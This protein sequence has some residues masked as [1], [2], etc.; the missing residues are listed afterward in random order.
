MSE[1]RGSGEYWRGLQKGALICDCPVYLL[2][3][4]LLT[5]QGPTVT[6][7]HLGFAHLTL[8]SENLLM[9]VAGTW[10]RMLS[11]TPKSSFFGGDSSRLNEV[12]FT[13]GAL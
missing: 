12:C 6:K 8:S 13:S 9:L 11:V 4:E 5:P 1:T 3:A 10:G 2:P 7:P